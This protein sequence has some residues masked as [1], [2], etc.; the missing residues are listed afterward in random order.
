MNSNHDAYDESL[1]EQILISLAAEEADTSPVS[2][3]DLKAAFY[4]EGFLPSTS[5]DEMLGQLLLEGPGRY[6]GLI[7]QGLNERSDALIE[8]LHAMERDEDRHTA[9]SRLGDV[10]VAR[11]WILRLFLRGFPQPPFSIIGDLLP[12]KYDVVMYRWWRPQE[13]QIQRYLC[14]LIVELEV[15]EA[16]L[17][18]PDAALPENPLLRFVVGMFQ[19]ARNRRFIRA[20]R[21]VIVAAENLRG[22]LITYLEPYLL[23]LHFQQDYHDYIDQ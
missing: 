3:A 15:I 13:S 23:N 20:I 8:Q 1:L 12:V 16:Y 10:L 11:Y 9:F 7:V 21:R 6:L 17:I 4:H 18:T 19:A 5:Q 22:H 14:D 2:D